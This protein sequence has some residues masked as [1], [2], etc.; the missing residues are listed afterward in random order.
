MA[1]FQ[2]PVL[3]LPPFGKLEYFSAYWRGSLLLEAFQKE[4]DLVVRAEREGPS[5]A[6]AAAMTRLLTDV[7]A[8]KS[9]ATEPM[10]DVHRRSGLMPDDLVGQPENIWNSLDPEEIEVSDASYYDNGRIAILMIFGSL[11]N[12]DFAPAIETAD[13][14][15]MQVLDGT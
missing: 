12:T 13:G 8:I 1:I 2:R 3:E 14:Q 6:Q 15:F 5:S 9:S 7:A 10:I 11:L 4:F